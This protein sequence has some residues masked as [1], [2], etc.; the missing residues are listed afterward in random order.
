MS[1]AARIAKRGRVAI[2]ASSNSAPREPLLFLY[3]SWNRN[4]L[5]TSAPHQQN[6]ASPKSIGQDAPIAVP[7]HAATLGEVPNVL[8]R[9]F[10][11]PKAA[12][13]SDLQALEAKDS[14]PPS[15]S[16][17][18]NITTEDGITSLGGEEAM[19]KAG[20]S[21]RQIDKMARRLLGLQ[22]LNEKNKLSAISWREEYQTI[23]REELELWTPDWRILLTT[24]IE[25]TPD[26][27]PWLTRALEFKM[28]PS[29]EARLVHGI[30]DYYLEIADQHGCRMELGSRNEDTHTFKTLLISGPA[31]AISKCAAGILRIAPDADIIPHKDSLASPQGFELDD[32]TRLPGIRPHSSDSE[33][34]FVME[35]QGPDRTLRDYVFQ[36]SP[37]EIPKPDGWTEFSFLRY[38]QALTTSR[39]TSHKNTYGLKEK[40]SHKSRVSAMLRALI[41]LPDASPFITREAFH[42]ILRFWVRHNQIEAAR[43]LFVHMEI[44][45]IKL[46]PETFNILLA[47]AAKFNDL[48]NFHYI[49]HLMLNRGVTPN[50]RTWTHFLVA[51]SD[52][53]V[54]LHIVTAMQKKGLLNHPRTILETAA[55]LAGPEITSS[56]E[57]GQSQQ[58]FIAHMD[59]RYGS[60]W[61]NNSSANHIIDEIASNGLISRCWEWLQ[62]MDSRGIV[63]D[64]YGL[65]TILH[66]CKQTANLRGAIEL[67]RSL[68]RSMKFKPSEETFRVMFD[69]AWE[70][71]CYNVAKVVWR[72]GCLTGALAYKVRQRVW[73]SMKNSNLA[74]PLRRGE[75]PRQRWIRQAGPIING[76][77]TI[78][79][80]PARHLERLVPELE[81]ERL[82]GREEERQTKARNE[83]AR[84]KRHEKSKKNA[85]KQQQDGLEPATE[86]LADSENPIPPP[87]TP[88]ELAAHRASPSYQAHLAQIEL[89]QVTDPWS[90]CIVG[91]RLPS[92]KKP[93]LK[94]LLFADLE[95][96]K[97]WEPIRPFEE[98]LV[99]A[100]EKDDEWKR[101]VDYNAKDLSWFLDGRAIRVGIKSYDGLVKEFD[102][103]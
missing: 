93:I 45:K 56:L 50:G 36:R 8:D 79:E 21:A 37:E 13:N 83:K 88:E 91:N 10:N 101:E 76:L 14:G 90:P 46:T 52:V 28:T 58:E 65:H 85:L 51:F 73:D 66:H 9:R 41:E 62:F 7:K 77:N 22:Q 71:R 92:Y 59:S 24:L 94:E 48:H 74:S 84:K 5:T 19:L 99:D 81:I 40:T 57:K 95:M 35:T 12:L 38:V 27:G 96:F 60:M 16:R 17:P 102:W 18:P 54:K 75:K 78:K 87:Y 53:K 68:P 42:E 103:R 26:H 25:H 55:Q 47:G 89:P 2:L 20:A 69:L 34:R 80:H 29:A 70:L 15:Q 72:Y 63:P 49:L 44:R 97:E 43:M 4:N 86:Q 11:K 31:T 82:V 23:K 39:V 61:L 98:M 6:G 30:D 67:L 100:M 32:G 3:P 33:L 1:L 64:E